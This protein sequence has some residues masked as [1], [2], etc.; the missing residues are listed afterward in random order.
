MDT[1][2]EAVFQDGVL[3]PLVPHNLEEHHHYRLSVEAL[4]TP[5]AMPDTNIAK[6]MADRVTRTP[7]G[8]VFVDILG[9]FDGGQD[10]P[11]FAA[12]ETI[13]DVY[14]Q[15]QAEESLSQGS[16]RAV[17]MTYVVDSIIRDSGLITVVWN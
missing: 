17:V 4:P 10:D 1:L 14:R 7:D 2:I 5:A 11:T 15:H 6:Q 3:R 8:R 13:G 12:I 9:L 16:A